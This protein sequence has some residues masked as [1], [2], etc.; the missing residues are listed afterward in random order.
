[1]VDN[2]IKILHELTGG[3]VDLFLFI[4]GTY[5]ETVKEYHK[6]VGKPVLPPFWGLGW[7]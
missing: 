4:D 1:M 7:H 3:L 5:E 2:K 6:I